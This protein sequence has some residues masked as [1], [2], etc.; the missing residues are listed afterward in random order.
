MTTTTTTPTTAPLPRSRH[1]GLHPARL[2]VPRTARGRGG[3]EGRSDEGRGEEGAS[4]V[5]LPLAFIAVTLLALTVVAMG[6]VLL[7]YQHLAG[8]ARASARYATRSE[9][10]PSRSPATSS[11]RPTTS[12]VVTF[13]KESADPLPADG[14]VGQ[15]SADN[16]SGRAGDEVTVTLEYQVSGGAFGFVTNTV[17]ALGGLI[18]LPDLPTVTLH[19]AAT[20]VYE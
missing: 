10:D 6:Q 20:G 14:V 16:L 3:D 7:D 5:E 18:G 13:A 15:L 11:R 9:Y 17:N 4:M 2:A 8:A 19:S 12:E 1:R